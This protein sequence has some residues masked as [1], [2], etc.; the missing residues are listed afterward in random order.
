MDFELNSFQNSTAKTWKS[1][2]F[3]NEKY[4]DVLLV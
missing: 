2:R 1:F 3:S 4:S